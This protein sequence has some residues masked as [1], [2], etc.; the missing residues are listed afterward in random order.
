MKSERDGEPDPRTMRWRFLLVD[1]P[2][3]AEIPSEI[4]LE[5][6]VS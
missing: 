5:L 4:I 1:W 3:A 2:A 6:Q